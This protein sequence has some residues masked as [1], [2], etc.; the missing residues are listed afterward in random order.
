MTDSSTSPVTALPNASLTF[1]VGSFEAL[2]IPSVMTNR[3]A[4]AEISG[5]E[6]L[7]VI[8]DR[9]DGVLGSFVKGGRS[10]RA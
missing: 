6:L 7:T 10:A 5:G 2:S 1:F 3:M 8:D 9:R 4:L